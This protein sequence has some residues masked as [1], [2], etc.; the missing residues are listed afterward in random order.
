[1]SLKIGIVGIGRFAPSFTLLMKHHPDVAEVVLCDTD[2]ERLASSAKR[3][4][5]KRTAASLEELLAMDVNAVA[6]FTP[7]HTH[8]PLALVALRAGKHVYSAVP[9]TID[10]ESLEEMV[11]TVKETGLVHMT[12][13][14]SLFYP[15][16][17]YCKKRFEAGDFGRFVYGEGQYLHDLNHYSV[18]MDYLRTKDDHFR[19]TAGLPPMFYSTHS[20]SM[21]LAATGAHVTE[22]ACMG[23]EDRE[24]DGVFGVGN[25]YWDNPFSNQTALMRTSDGGVLRINEMRRIGWRAPASGSVFMSLYGT[26]A[27]F[28][29]NSRSAF[30]VTLDI[31]DYE[32]VFE[33]QFKISESETVASALGEEPRRTDPNEFGGVAPVHPVE[34]LPDTYR[35]LPNPNHGGSHAFLVNA[36]VRALVDGHQPPGNIF[37]AANWT[38]AGLLAHE[39]ALENGAPKQVPDFAKPAEA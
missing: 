21:P 30:W 25:N 10:M 19:K 11:T 23:I 32:D 26:K 22:V 28:E 36:F 16:T 24:E 4:G 27:S 3:F 17:I 29:Q 12:G 1:M 14:T 8:G 37:E 6:L 7:R 20:I 34:E 9:P 2:S 35:G 15:W 13:E 39:S 18:F 5:V 33:S 31:D 38:A